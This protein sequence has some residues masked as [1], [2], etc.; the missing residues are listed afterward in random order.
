MW[1]SFRLVAV[2][3]FLVPFVFYAQEKTK[4][5]KF[6]SEKTFHIKVGT[7]LNYVNTKILNALNSSSTDV[8]TSS[9]NLSFNPSAEIEFDNQFS[10]HVGFNIAFGVM[11]TRLFY[12]YEDLSFVPYQYQSYSS[13]PQFQQNKNGVIISTIPHLNISPSF[14]IS[15]TRFNIGLGFYKYY[16]T[17]NPKSM[18]GFWFN[19]NAEGYAI[20][21]NVGIT[22]AFDIKSYKFTASVNYFGFTKKYDQGFQVALGIAL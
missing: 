10:K 3:L 5:E 16:Y 13:S 21:S 8:F 4:K 18:G 9:K 2:I 11:Q 19:L 6:V 1:N 12:H 22:Q 7:T 20:Y 14:Y 15:N 17:F